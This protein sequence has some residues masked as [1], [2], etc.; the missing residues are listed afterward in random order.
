MVRA[1]RTPCPIG[2]VFFYGHFPLIRAD[3][4]RGPVYAGGPTGRRMLRSGAPF[5][6]SLSFNGAR[7]SRL[8]RRIN[9]RMAKRPAAAVRIPDS[10]AHLA[11]PIDSLKPWPQNPR[12]GDL[13]AIR[14]S[15]RVNAQFRP[16]LYRAS[17]RVILAGNHTWHAACADGWTE[18]AAQP[19]EPTDE[20]HAKRIVLADNRTAAIDSTLVARYYD[21]KRANGYTTEE[22]DRKRLALE[23]VLV[24]L[25]GRWNEDALREAGYRQVDCFWR[26]LNFAGWLAVK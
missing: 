16:I 21:M 5:G 23:G 2:T 3:L 20:A 13:E 26:Y 25:T 14:E 12:K 15:L 24:P 8:F 10:L 9:T 6:D 4:R 19:I 17:D 11:V 7:C 1:R 18:I 22:I